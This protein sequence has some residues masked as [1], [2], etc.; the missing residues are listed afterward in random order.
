MKRRKIRTQRARV[1]VLKIQSFFVLL[2]VVV[3]LMTSYVVLIGLSVKNVIIRKEAETKTALLRAEVSEMEREY[4]T[5]VGD[6]T[7]ARADGVGLGKVVIKTYAERSIL[8][9]QAY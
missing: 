6:I 3:L 9:G 8:V 7:L 4:I 1:Q 5:R 2:L